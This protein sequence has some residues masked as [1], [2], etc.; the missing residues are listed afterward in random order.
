MIRSVS[1]APD[2]SERVAAVLA[3]ATA[4]SDELR[5]TIKELTAILRHGEEN[6]ESA[7]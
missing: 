7:K 1:V 2:R 6:K 4:L 5:G 3:R